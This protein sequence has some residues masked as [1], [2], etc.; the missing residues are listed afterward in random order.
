M[1]NIHFDLF[2]LE[3]VVKEEIKFTYS[4]QKQN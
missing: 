3:I 2:S 1:N 4:E